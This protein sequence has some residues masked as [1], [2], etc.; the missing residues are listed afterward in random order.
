MRRMAYTV[1]RRCEVTQD[2]TNPTTTTIAKFRIL[3]YISVHVVEPPWV[4]LLRTHFM[5]GFAGIASVPHI[6][7]IRRIAVTVR[8]IRSSPTS[9]LPFLR[10]RKMKIEPRSFSNRFYEDA[11]AA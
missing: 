3:P 9:A 6:V 5:R 1:G 2:T 11:W 7:T 10:S 8:C 4:W